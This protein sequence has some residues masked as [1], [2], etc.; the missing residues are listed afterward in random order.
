MVAHGFEDANAFLQTGSAIGVAAGAVGFIER[1]FEDKRDAQLGG[2]GGEVIGQEV[3]M[4]FA[5]DD[6][7]SG[8]QRQRSAAADSNRAD[9]NR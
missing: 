3:D 2:F 1:S 6:A 9:V 5:F 4:L 7:G 8:D